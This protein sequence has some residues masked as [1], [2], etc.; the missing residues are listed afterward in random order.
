MVQVYATV[1]TVTDGSG[2]IWV[3][4]PTVRVSRRGVLMEQGYYATFVGDG[5]V[6]VRVCGL[7]GR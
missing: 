1:T 5:Y 7:W 3:D 2:C 6:M 4:E